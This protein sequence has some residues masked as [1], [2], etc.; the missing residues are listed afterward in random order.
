MELGGLG[1]GSTHYFKRMRFDVDLKP[2][3]AAG[4]R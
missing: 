3:A 4:A 1:S 2:R